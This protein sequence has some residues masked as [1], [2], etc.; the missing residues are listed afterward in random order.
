LVFNNISF[1]LISA[2]LTILILVFSEI[3]PKTIGAY[4]WKS[5]AMGSAKIINIMVFITY[6]LVVISEGLTKIISKGGKV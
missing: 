5:I 6:P 3:L 1:G 4:Y 2:T